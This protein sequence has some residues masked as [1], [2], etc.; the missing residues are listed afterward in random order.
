[1]ARSPAAPPRAVS[2]TATPVSSQEV[3]IPRT[4]MGTRMGAQG[5]QV[6]PTD[7]NRTCER[8]INR[9]TICGSPRERPA[10]SYS[11]RFHAQR[12]SPRKR[13]VRVCP[14]PLQAHLR[15]GR[16]PGRNPQ[17][18][19]LREADPGA[20]AQGR[21][22]REAPG[23][24]RRPRRHQAP[25]PVLTGCPARAGRLAQLPR[26]AGHALRRRLFF[27]PC[28][29][30]HRSAGDP[31]MTLKQTL[32]EDMKAAMKAGEKDRLGVI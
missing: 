1:C 17:A 9:A 26:E 11:R 29:R 30:S 13:A 20:Q 18:R 8:N 3:S 31:S 25:A 24:P 32:T 23:A 12:Q 2:Y 5:P 15:E 16:C 7:G 10:K 19:V 22:C 27:V 14:A 4:R 28:P 21:G 6:T